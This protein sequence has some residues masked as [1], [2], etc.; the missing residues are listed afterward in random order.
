MS[1]SLRLFYWSLLPLLIACAVAAVI[2]RGTDLLS[3]SDDQIA[4]ITGT[5]LLGNAAS[6]VVYVAA[7]ITRSREHYENRLGQGVAACCALFVPGAFFLIPY[8]RRRS[9]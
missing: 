8:L 3:L 6:G 4:A 2:V 9:N 5:F 7:C 1:K